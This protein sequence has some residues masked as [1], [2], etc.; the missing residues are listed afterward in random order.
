MTWHLLP[1]SIVF[2]FDRIGGTILFGQ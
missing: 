1:F 2:S